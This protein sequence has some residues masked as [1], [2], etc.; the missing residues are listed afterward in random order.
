M[1]LNFEIR[2]ITI[3]EW[4]PDRCLSITE[5]FIP[6]DL[7][8]EAGCPSLH[9]T[10]Q[11]NS[12]EQMVAWYREALERFECCGFV[13]WMGNAVIG[14]NTFFPQSI[15]HKIQFY[16][17]GQKEDSSPTTLIHN[18]ISILHNP[19]F[20][21]KSIGSQLIKNS[22]EWAKRNGWKRFEVHNVLPATPSGFI[23]EQKSTEM[24][25]KKFGFQI[26]RTEEG[27]QETKEFY[28]VNTRYSMALELDDY[29]M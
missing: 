29:S 9:H 4:L 26:F 16:G 27:C 23:S 2:Q 14:H 3:E 1:N 20:H 12:R 28:G 8:P 25:W 10:F 5:P 22:L 11:N 7:P 24:F 15:A 13:A 17:W 21:H 19:D 18:C 6:Y